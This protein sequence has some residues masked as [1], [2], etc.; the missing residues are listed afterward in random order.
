MKD[1]DEPFFWASIE[2]FEMY[3]AYV[4]SYTYNNFIHMIFGPPATKGRYGFDCGEQRAAGPDFYPGSSGISGYIPDNLKKDIEKKLIS[5][6]FVK[7]I[8]TKM[9]QFWRYSFP[10]LLQFSGLAMLMG[11]LLFLKLKPEVKFLY[12]LC[13]SL[14]FYNAI[15]TAAFAEPLLRYMIFSFEFQIVCGFIG[16][17]VFFSFAYKKIRNISSKFLPITQSS[18]GLANQCLIESPTVKLH[19]PKTSMAL[20]LGIWIVISM[21]YLNTY[22]GAP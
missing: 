21:F 9:E 11:G 22:L 10:K 5:K 8:F 4:L 13:A 6:E 17:H 20:L 15:I 18:S 12:A 7:P 14:C 3:P 16:V 2:L 19:Q 1:R